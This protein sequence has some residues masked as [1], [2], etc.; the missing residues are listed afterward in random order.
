MKQP[1]QI[2]G[3]EKSVNKNI[4]KDVKKLEKSVAPTLKTKKGYI[5]YKTLTFLEPHRGKITGP[6]TS[7]EYKERQ[8]ANTAYLGQTPG[9]I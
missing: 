3:L 8:D 4:P 2:S 6:P 9:L 1:T 7:L 5:I